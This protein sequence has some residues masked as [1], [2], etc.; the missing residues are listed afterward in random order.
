MKE[1][2]IDLPREMV[3][4][5][6]VITNPDNGQIKMASKDIFFT[7]QKEYN[8]SQQGGENF[9]PPLWLVWNNTIPDQDSDSDEILALKSSIQA[10]LDIDISWPLSDSEPQKGLFNLW[11]TKPSA[12]PVQINAVIDVAI[13]FPSSAKVADFVKFYNVALKGVGNKVLEV[14][15]SIVSNI[16]ID[17][18]TRDYHRRRENWIIEETQTDTCKI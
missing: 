11:F 5:I 8:Q 4:D 16:L 18:L 7:Y 9:S 13:N 1:G 15:V 3:L 10:A 6:D 17:L 12:F 2:K 14:I